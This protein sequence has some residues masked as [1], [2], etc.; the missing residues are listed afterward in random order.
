MCNASYIILM[1]VKARLAASTSS[2]IAYRQCTP[3]DLALIDI[4][5]LDGGDRRRP[6]A[7]NYN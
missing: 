3:F 2:V 1:M 4:G 7:Q 5:R 6:I